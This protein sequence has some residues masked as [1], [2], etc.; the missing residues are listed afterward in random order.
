M[1]DGV[2][3]ELEEELVIARISIINPSPD[4]LPIAKR[5][6]GMFRGKDVITYG[7]HTY[8]YPVENV[9]CQRLVSALQKE[10]PQLKVDVGVSGLEQG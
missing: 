7:R 2:V 4:P 10:Y 8:R 5:F 3:D 6:R 1:D 9:A